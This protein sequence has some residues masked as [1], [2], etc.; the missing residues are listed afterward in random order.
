MPDWKEMLA[1]MPVQRVNSRELYAISKTGFFITDSNHKLFQEHHFKEWEAALAEFDATRTVDPD[2]NRV[3]VRLE[4]KALNHDDDGTWDAERYFTEVEGEILLGE[5][6][7]KIGQVELIVARYGEAAEAVDKP[8]RSNGFGTEAIKA[9]MQEYRY[10]DL[11]AVKPYAIEIDREQ[12][13]TTEALR[14][15][16]RLQN[17]YER[18]GFRLIGEEYMTF[19]NLNRKQPS[20]AES[21]KLRKRW[22]AKKP[23]LD[24]AD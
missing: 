1:N 22:L 2:D 19:C 12:Q 17:L 8:F 21:R 3:C 20:L 23:K 10:C 9:I 11:I 13:D 18:L 15:Q 6:E 7:N 16:K 4:V 24:E 5:K 14:T